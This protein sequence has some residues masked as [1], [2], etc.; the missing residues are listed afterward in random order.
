M[1]TV[2]GAVVP[3]GFLGCD[4]ADGLFSVPEKARSPLK[5]SK[6][7]IGKFLPWVRIWSETHQFPGQNFNQMNSHPTHLCQL[8][9][10]ATFRAGRGLAKPAE[11]PARL[12]GGGGKWG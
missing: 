12:G 3:T 5:L 1:L 11:H 9:M 4:L 6:S 8:E 2:W 10:E 7:S